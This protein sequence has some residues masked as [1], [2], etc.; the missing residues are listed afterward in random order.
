MPQ[1][2]LYVYQVL[3]KSIHE[4]DVFGWLKVT[5]VKWCKVEGKCE[6]HGENLRNTKL[7][8]ELLDQFSSNLG[9]RVAYGG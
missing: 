6:E 2:A 5:F 7:P 9:G 8:C 3:K 4:K 1:S